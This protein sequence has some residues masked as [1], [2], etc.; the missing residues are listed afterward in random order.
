LETRSRF[1]VP[2]CVFNFGILTPYNKTQLTAC[3]LRRLVNNHQLAQ[4]GGYALS[5]LEAQFSVG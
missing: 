3:E 1:L 2:L 5:K 4:V